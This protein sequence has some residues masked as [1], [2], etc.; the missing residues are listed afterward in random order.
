MTRASHPLPTPVGL[1]AGAGELPR[2]VARSLRR[3]GRSVSAVALRGSAEPDL[4]SLCDRFRWAGVA[5]PGSWIRALR[6]D[7]CREVVMVGRVRK[8]KIFALPRWLQWLLYL[9][10]LTAV[11]IWYRRTPDKRNDSL[12]RAVA[13]E[14]E[15]RGLTLVDSTRYLP[16][17]LVAEGCLTRARPAASVEADI[18]FAWPLAKHIAGL[19]IGQAV[20]VKE[21]EIIAVEAIEGT[22]LLIERTAALCPVGGWTLVKVA[23][24]NQDMRFDVPTIGPITIDKLRAARAACLVVEAGRTIILERERTLAAADAARLPVVG[25][26]DHPHPNVL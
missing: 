5:R 11:R 18:D 3:S 8:A 6:A 24:P 17:S 16:D 4:K 2:L 23:K 12:L 10:D 1:V 13:D 9:P 14:F 25:R 22:D 7:G 21:R 19:D 26:L 20:T 15:R